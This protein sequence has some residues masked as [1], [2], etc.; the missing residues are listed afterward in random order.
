MKIILDKNYA[1]APDVRT[2]EKYSAGEYLV[3]ETITEAAASAALGC[4]IAREVKPAAVAET[5][6]AAPKAAPKRKPRAK[7]AAAK[8]G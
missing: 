6:T 3:G 7:K 4:G 2:T 8:K 5:K 1:F